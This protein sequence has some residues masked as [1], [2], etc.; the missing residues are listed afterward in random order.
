MVFI[1]SESKFLE[2]TRTALTNAQTHPQIKAAL[3][4]FGID[5]A[6]FTEGW[7]F[8]DNGRETWEL[9]QKEESETRVASNTYSKAF[10]Q[11]EMTFKRHRELTLILCKKDPD[12][13]IYLG[14]KGN[15]PL[16]YNE[17]FDKVK[18]FYTTITTNPAV[19]A[20]LAIIKL[21]P[22]VATEYLAELDNLLAHRAEFDKEMG[23][24]Q[25]T[26]VIKNAKLH[27]LSEWMDEFDTIAKIALYDTPQQLE[28]LGVLVKS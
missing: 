19:Q 8:Y 12:T 7:L 3:A 20:K 6:K 21:T 9:N 17:F 22:E 23:E 28:V 25:A 4:E 11:L 5:E 26:T 15:F 24:S 27:E 16:Q 18:L 14:V 10:N 2:R 13:L 1:R